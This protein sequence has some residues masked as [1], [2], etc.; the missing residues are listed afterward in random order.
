MTRYD[1][2]ERYPAGDFV[3][4]HPGGAGIPAFIA[5]RPGHRRRRH[6]P[7]AHLRPHAGPAPGRLAGHAGRALRLHP[8]AHP[9]SS[10]ATRPW[11]SRRRLRTARPAP[12][13]DKEPR[14]SSRSSRLRTLP[15]G[16]RGSSSRTS[17][18]SGSLNSLGPPRP[19]PPRPAP[20][21]PPTPSDLAFR[22]PGFCG[23]DRGA[24]DL[25]DLSMSWWRARLTRL[26]SPRGPVRA[27]R[28]P[29]S[30]AGNSAPSPGCSRPKITRGHTCALVGRR[31]AT[32]L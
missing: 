14:S 20:S 8:Q 29:P 13:L 3:N 32:A 31:I 2:A 28:G 26:F 23:E 24:G 12:E 10:T 1:P 25:H 16:L 7:V 22:T 27:R 19:A 9:A 17:S 30:T 21:T 18:R 4:Q 15:S 5:G 11:T 6:R